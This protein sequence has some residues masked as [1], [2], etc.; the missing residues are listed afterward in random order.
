MDLGK[1]ASQTDIDRF[2]EFFESEMTY[3]GTVGFIGGT[4]QAKW[5]P[6]RGSNRDMQ[7]LE[8]QIYLV[9]KIA[10]VFGL[11]P[12][13]LGVTFDVNR[14]TSEIQLQISEDRGLR[15]LMS[16]VQDYFT[17]EIVWD[18]SF[19]GQNNNLAFRYKALNLKESTARAEM[20]KLSLAGVP[21]K[22]FNEARVDEGR[23]PVPSMEGKIIMATPQGA[24][25]ISDVP[26]VREMLE[27][28]AASR[29]PDP[30]K[31]AGKAMDI[32]VAAP[33]FTPLADMINQVAMNQNEF[34]RALIDIAGRQQPVP[35]VSIDKGAVEVNIGVASGMEPTRS[36]PRTVNRESKFITN[37]HGRI[38]GKTETETIEDEVLAF[39]QPK[40]KMVTRAR[41]ITRDSNFI[42]DDDGRIIGKTETESES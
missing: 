3:G 1:G 25:D 36:E 20:N 30:P 26:T 27:M 35:Q 40:P 22:M 28:Q 42:A 4:E 15:P 39:E 31:P 6:L 12:Q 7:F 19:G 23:E 8:W 14:S 17:K 33:D 10:V 41:T 21:W 24:V 13:D 29:K 37:E 38:V 18:A 34:Q 9:R 32:N 11:S 16:L 2:R 5:I